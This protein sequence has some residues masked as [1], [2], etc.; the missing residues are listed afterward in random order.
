MRE[1]EGEQK[2]VYKH[3]STLDSLPLLGSEQKYGFN[4]F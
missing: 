4:L 3:N 1:R 2:G